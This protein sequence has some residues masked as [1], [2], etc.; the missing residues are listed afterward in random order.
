MSGEILFTAKGGG[1][2]IGASCYDYLFDDELVRVDCGLRPLNFNS[3]IRLYHTNDKE[4]RAFLDEMLVKPEVNPLPDLDT[5]GYELKHLLVT[6]AHLDHSAAI[7]YLLRQ[8][9]YTNVY[10]T[11]VTAKL[12]KIQWFSTPR[13]AERRGEIPLFNESDAEFALSRIVEIRHDRRIK[14]NDKLEVEPVHAGHLLG[15]VSYIFYLN[16]EPVGCHTGDLTLRNNQRSVP[17]APRVR[18]DHLRF[19]TIDSTRLTELNPPRHIEEKRLKETV[20]EAYDEGMK[21]RILTF[22][23]G[24]IQEIFALVREACPDADIWVDGQGRDVSVIYAEHVGGEFADIEKYFVRNKTQRSEIIHSKK[25]NIVLSPSA[26]QFGGFSRRYVEYGCGQSDHLFISPGY[27]DP[28]SPE[29]AFFASTSH[30]DVFEFEAYR[31]ARMC[32]TATFNFTAH[33]DGEDVLDT[34]DRTN[35]EKVHLVHGDKDK[36]DQ[37]VENHPNQEFI[38]VENN[39]PLSV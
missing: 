10:M 34:V 20:R 2:E 4:L 11:P 37:F 1:N 35:P 21:V 39:V 23:F 7:P 22:A 6:H 28:R 13:I 26:M 16:G 29:Y 18:F 25:P 31:S 9:R 27:R 3:N 15:A 12:S 24:R 30:N 5:G 36:T 8:H 38:A 32:Q 14:L 19:L 17:D 33:C